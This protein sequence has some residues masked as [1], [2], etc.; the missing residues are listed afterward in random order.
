MIIGVVVLSYI[1]AAQPRR[2]DTREEKQIV[3]FDSGA[4]TI[5]AVPLESAETGIA[6]GL[7]A[8]LAKDLAGIP[9]VRHV[10]TD[11]ADGNLLVWIAIDRADSYDV[12]QQ[13]YE[14]ELG[15]MDGFPEVNFD[16]NLI[17]AGGRS[18]KDLAT[19]AQ[20]IYSRA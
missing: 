18:P 5:E 4:Q 1:L 17:P 11:R 2:S 20:I 6:V 13:V 19:G 10:L 7:E 15:L 8:A 12:R 14:K 3:V 9:E 16:F